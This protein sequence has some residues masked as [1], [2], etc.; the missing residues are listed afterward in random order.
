MYKIL[1]W[2]LNGTNQAGHTVVCGTVP[3]KSGQL[4][5]LWIDYI[6][7]NGW[8]KE[9]MSL[10]CN[11]DVDVYMNIDCEAIEGA[12][13]LALSHSLPYDVSMSSGSMLVV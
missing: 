5:G 1:R 8:V 12:R 10:K 2:Q 9:Y 7:I 3:S 6:I 4:A 11:V 13:F